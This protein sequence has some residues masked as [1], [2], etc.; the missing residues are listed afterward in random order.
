M[1]GHHR[2]RGKKGDVQPHTQ[3]QDAGQSSDSG[4]FWQGAT[5]LNTTPHPEER[6]LSSWENLQTFPQCNSDARHGLTNPTSI[7][8]GECPQPAGQYFEHHPWLESPPVQALEDPASLSSLLS[9]PKLQSL[10]F[11]PASISLCLSPRLPS[12]HH[13]RVLP[14]P[15]GGIASLHPWVPLRGSERDKQGSREQDPPCQT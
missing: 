7:L 15:S 11:S 14:P 13:S 10:G 5:A 6:S 12:L 8:T 3:V 9:H 4:P 1:L 2:A